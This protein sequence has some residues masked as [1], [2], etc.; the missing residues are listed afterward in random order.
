ERACGTP[1][2]QLGHWYDERRARAESAAAAAGTGD[3][4]A[5]ED[6]V[7]PRVARPVVAHAVRTV[8]DQA[9]AGLPEAWRRSVRDAAWRGADGLPEALDEVVGEGEE[10]GGALPKPPRAVWWTAAFAGQAALL[11]LQLVGVVWVLGTAAGV[12]LGAGWMAVALLVGGALG[13]S[14]L[15]W[16]CRIAAGGPAEAYGRREEMR[17]RRLVEGCGESRVL[18][19]VAT[20]MLRYREVREQYVIA[21]SEAQG[22]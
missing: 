22:L 14:L 1:W 16:V 20:E 7:C 5:P 2:T 17:L 13:G 11:A 15:A 12:T 3:D 18:K 9:A 4:D 19:P 10:P 8:V 6:D 21:A